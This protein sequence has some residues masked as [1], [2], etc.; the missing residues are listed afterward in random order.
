MGVRVWCDDVTVDNNRAEMRAVSQ[1]PLQS[2]LFN[3]FC[4]LLFL[5]NF[6][7]ATLVEGESEVG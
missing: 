7:T 4:F 2:T 1:T 6:E 3:V 5:L